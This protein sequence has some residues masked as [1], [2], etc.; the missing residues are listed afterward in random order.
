ARDG[1]RRPD[2]RAAGLRAADRERRADRRAHRRI[3]PAGDP[4][5]G[6]SVARP[7]RA[8]PRA[9]RVMTDVLSIPERRVEGREK[10]TGAAAYA[11]DVRRE[12]MLHAV[13]VGS[14]YAHA[15]IVSVNIARARE[16]PGVRAVLTGADVRGHRFGRRLQD[17]PVLAWDRVRFI[18]DR[19]AV[20]AADTLAAAEEAA[21]LID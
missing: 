13:F 12:G 20:V 17:W 10:V 1:R 4:A 9:D 15:R 3:R 8:V 7:V 19:V 11:A 18:G 6:R 16:V 2:E 14:P 21:R 5:Q